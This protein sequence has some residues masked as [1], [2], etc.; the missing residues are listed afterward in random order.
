VDYQAEVQIPQSLPRRVR[1]G[2]ARGEEELAWKPCC[3]S[4]E[5]LPRRP[6]ASDCEWS[7][8]SRSACSLFGGGTGAPE[9]AFGAR[10][11][12]ARGTRLLGAERRVRGCSRGSRPS[13]RFSSEDPLRRAEDGCFAA[14]G[15][16]LGAAA[17][18]DG[19]ESLE[20]SSVSPGQLEVL[21]VRFEG[22]ARPACW[23]QRRRL[24]SLSKLV[25][26]SSALFLPMLQVSAMETLIVDGVCFGL[27]ERLAPTPVCT[28]TNSELRQPLHPVWRSRSACLP[29]TPASAGLPFTDRPNVSA[30]RGLR[31]ELVV[32]LGVLEEVY[33]LLGLLPDSSVPVVCAAGSTSRSDARLGLEACDE[34]DGVFWVASWLRTRL[35]HSRQS[36][37]SVASFWRL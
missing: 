28:S 13:A 5:R 1:G 6:A 33:G 18:R 25:K 10:R 14:D 37:A 7:V 24:V 12:P 3:L 31:T 30:F 2:E 22:G 19:G 34:L 4:K 29:G 32:V 35:P 17:G 8:R 20:C 27:C 15:P 21:Q 16:D 36:S 11:W 9:A 26:A 23:S